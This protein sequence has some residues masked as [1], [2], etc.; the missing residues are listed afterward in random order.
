MSGLYNQENIIRLGQ[1]T[2]SLDI[3]IPNEILDIIGENLKIDFL[4]GAA[5]ILVSKA[6]D[7]YY[8]GVEATCSPEN[9]LQLTDGIKAK[10]RLEPQTP[11]LCK[12]HHDGGYLVIKRLEKHT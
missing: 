12:Y 7:R 9:V 2:D 1:V 6:D 11:V 10:M 8:T 4:L 3:E 5:S